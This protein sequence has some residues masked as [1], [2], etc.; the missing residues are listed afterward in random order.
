MKHSTAITWSI[1]AILVAVIDGIIKSLAIKRLPE[2]GGHLGS[3]IGFALHKNPGIAFDIPI[4]LTV[5]IVLT[6]VITALLAR[7]AVRSWIS[8]PERSF[9]AVIIVIGAAGNMIDRII[10]GFTTDYIILFRR[11]A[12]NLSDILIILGTILIL[13]YNETRTKKEKKFLGRNKTI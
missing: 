7:Y 10:N 4:P 11:S 8:R 6:V 5:I 2:A 1:L 3:P 9:A 12:I 13:Y